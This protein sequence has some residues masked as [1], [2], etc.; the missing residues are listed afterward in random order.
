MLLPLLC[1]IFLPLIE[2][3]TSILAKKYAKLHKIILLIIVAIAILLSISLPISQQI[4]SINFGLFSLKFMCDI[5]SYFF[6]IL[7][8]VIWFLTNL[9]AYSYIRI[10]LRRN[11]LIKFFQ[12]LSLSIFA[13]LGGAYSADLWT[14]FIFY[15]LL[16]IFTANLIVQNPSKSSLKAQKIYLITQLGTALLLF[17]PAIILL[18]YLGG[19]IDFVNSSNE[20]LINNREIAT[21][22]LALFIFGIA[23]NCIFPFGGWITYST[24]APNPVSALLHSVAAVKSGS[25]AIMKIAVYIFGINYIGELTSNFFTGGWI[26]Y[27]CGFTALYASYQALKATDIKKRFAYST[28][29]QLS[30]IVS[31]IMIGTPLGII[32]AI[33]HIIS[34][35]FS[36]VVLFYIAG[37]FNGVYKTRNTEQIAKIAPHMKF[38]IGCLAFAGAS[39][40]GFPFLPGSY[41]KDYM[42]LSELGTHHYAAIIFLIA[43]SLINILYIYPIVKAAFFNKNPEPIEIKAIPFFMR[44]AILVGIMLSI[45]MGFNVSTLVKFLKIYII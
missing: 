16:I 28:T 18:Q 45:L 35:S 3:Q 40:I 25:I 41:G 9:Y 24:V 34:H 27:V 21:L 43:G 36:K 33:L 22:L 30:Y 39:I 2:L 11:R 12:N 32:A 19:N 37:I 42:I 1:L 31:S 23:K 29:S 44:L 20:V 13:V 8:T 14:L 7:V 6:G 15:F 17:L 26:F 10:V 38:W 4:Y 5:Y